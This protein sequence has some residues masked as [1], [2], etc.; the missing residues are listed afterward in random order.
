VRTAFSELLEA[1]IHHLAS[2]CQ[3]AGE[4]MTLATEALL[5]ADLLL[6]ESVIGRH[7]LFGALT[8][9]AEQS[10]FGSLALQALVGRDLRDIVATVKNT[11]D[12]QQMGMLALDVAKIARRRHPASA[13]PADIAHDF[14]SM[15]G[16]AV[17]LGHNVRDAVLARDLLT[18]ARC[19]HTDDAMRALH[20]RLL[21][22]LA[23]REWICG[24]SDAIDV[25]LLGRLYERFADHG[26]RIARRSASIPPANEQPDRL[27]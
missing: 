24:E 9:E 14:A 19:R 18:A 12:A 17:E 21:A 7:E 22:A 13:L 11:A 16:L 3:A 27:R 20:R 1:L 4:A 8:A 23:D 15:G 5:G 6:A 2:M 26:A 10:A 25:T